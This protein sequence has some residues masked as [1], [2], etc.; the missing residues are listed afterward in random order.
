MV[1]EVNTSGW[2]QP[3]RD[4]Y[5]AP[6][7]IRAARE[8]DIPITITADAHHPR[9]LSRDFDRALGLVKEAGYDAV[10]RFE[11]RSRETIALG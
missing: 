2:N 8:R 5:P 4:V 10:V 1:V 11:R 3:A 6:W 9:H 7:I